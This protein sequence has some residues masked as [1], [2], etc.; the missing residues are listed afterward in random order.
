MTVCKPSRAAPAGIA[1]ALA[2]GIVC[3][4]PS[5]AKTAAAQ[6]SKPDAATAALVAEV[7]HSFTIHG[8]PI[9]PE[10]F[11]DFGDGDM[12]D[13]GSIWVT[14]DVLA[15]TGSNLYYDPISQPDGGFIAQIK[16]DPQTKSWERT[17]Y[18]FIGSTDNGLLVVVAS[19]SGGGSGV[20]L[21]LHILDLAAVRAFEDGDGKPYWRIDLTVIR[22]IALGDR[23]DGG[24]AIKMNAIVV[25][26]THSGPADDKGAPP[27]TI[28]AVRP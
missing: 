2:L 11:R 16:T 13:S 25:T 9:P 12:A 21:T 26:T 8:K 15:A 7:R 3:S 5:F 17:A 20:F 4:A 24:V 23:W 1:V 10:I 22:S 19:Y 14:V 27:M 18:D 28:T 6:T